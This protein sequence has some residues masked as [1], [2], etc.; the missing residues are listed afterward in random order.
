M[1]LTE[2]GQVSGRIGPPVNW[3]AQ[4][5]KN[6]KPQKAVQPLLDGSNLTV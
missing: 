3:T 4:T 1:G 6:N 2:L 5:L